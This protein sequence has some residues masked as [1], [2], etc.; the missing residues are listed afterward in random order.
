MEQMPGYILN[1]GSVACEDGLSVDNLVLLGG[2]IDVPQADGVVVTGRE[3]VSVEVGIP[4]QAVALLLVTPQSQ[5]WLALATRVRLAWVFCVVK[6]KHIA[7]WR[8]GGNDTRVLR[9]VP[10]P[11]HLPLMVDLD[12]NLNLARDGAKPTKLSLLVVI[13]G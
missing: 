3:E 11:V 10:G 5:V 9:H 4:G 8:L 2:G 1:N 13:V 12:L 7:T 6:H